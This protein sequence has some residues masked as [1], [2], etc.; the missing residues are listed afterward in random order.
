MAQPLNL[1]IFL[2][3]ADEPAM[4]RKLALLLCIALDKHPDSDWR[5]LRHGYR[6]DVDAMADAMYLTF[7][8][9]H[10]ESSIPYIGEEKA[11]NNKEF[12]YLGCRLVKA[13]GLGLDACRAAA[14]KGDSR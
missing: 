4:Q 8:E 12:T 9:E 3:Y 5:F 14:R 7:W 10:S 6:E 1:Q 2:E 11:P 13:R